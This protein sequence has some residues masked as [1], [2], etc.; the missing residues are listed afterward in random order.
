MT[1]TALRQKYHELRRKTN[2]MLEVYLDAALRSKSFDPAAFE[3]NYKLPKLIL[4]SALEECRHQ[5]RPTNKADAKEI[6]NITLCSYP[7]FTKL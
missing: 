1:K 6:Q 5:W 2:R 3:D 4:A 7:D